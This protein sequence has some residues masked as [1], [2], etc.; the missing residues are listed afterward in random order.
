MKIN[1]TQIKCK[2]TRKGAEVSLNFAEQVGEAIYQTGK[3]RLDKKLA[4]KVGDSTGEIELTDEEVTT[5]KN[6][7]ANF[8]FWAKEALWDALGEKAE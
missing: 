7:T 8:L 4:D 2:P 1:F 6:A 3:T 5:V